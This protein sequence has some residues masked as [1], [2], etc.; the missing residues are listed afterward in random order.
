[1]RILVGLGAFWLGTTLS[2][3]GGAAVAV[4][5]SPAWQAC[6]GTTAKPDDRVSACTVVID[7]KTETGRKLAAAYCNRG[8]GLTDKSQ[9]DAAFADLNEAVRI[10]PNYPCAYANR[11]RVYVLRGD[12]DR[13]MTDYNE[14]I[15]LD[16]GFALAYSNRGNAHFLK[17]DLDR[18]LADF[19]AAIK[20]EP[21]LAIAYG[22]R[23]YLYYRKHDAARAI[24]DYTTQIK[25]VPDV[26]AYINRGNAYRDSEQLDLAAAD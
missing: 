17:G 8:E 2:L 16:P 12:P 15:R 3:A 13:A 14:A 23:G 6:I 20:L 9:L 21:A 18:A 1:M 19:N 24:E 7:A 5:G 25:L 26:L 4:E 11:G 10:D 22:N